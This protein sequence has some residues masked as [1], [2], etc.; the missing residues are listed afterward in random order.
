ML[1]V[2][3]VVGG[4]VGGFSALTGAFLRKPRH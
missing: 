2:T 3:A 1:A 4:L